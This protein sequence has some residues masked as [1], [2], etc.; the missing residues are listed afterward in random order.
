[1]RSMVV[2]LA[3]GAMLCSSI[4]LA[5]PRALSSA[6]LDQVTAGASI[7]QSIVDAFTGGAVA[8]A[9][10]PTTPSVTQNPASATGDG[11]IAVEG[12]TNNTA[13]AIA[14][15]YSTAMNGE[16]NVAVDVEQSGGI[17]AEGSVAGSDNTAHIQND[18]GTQIMVGNVDLS[19]TDAFKVYNTQNENEIDGNGNFAFNGTNNAEVTITSDNSEVDGEIERGGAGVIAKEATVCD[20]FNVKEVEND[21]DVDISDS[22]NTE[23]NTLDISGQCTVSGIINANSLGFQNIAANLNVT[24]S[25]SSTPN[26]APTETLVGLE[27][28]GSAAITVLSQINVNGSIGVAIGNV[29]PIPVATG[30]L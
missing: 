4:A 3:V 30:V 29:V 5:T 7:G 10:T 28:F 21:V 2:V 9:V 15:H 17:A 27:G 25:T 23:T 1:M 8:T 6:E 11:S 22:F 12:G 18:G 26:N 14:D 20:S 24:T 13:G 16:G 19:I